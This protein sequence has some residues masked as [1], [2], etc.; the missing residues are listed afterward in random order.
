MDGVGRAEAGRTPGPALALAAHPRRALLFAADAAG[1]VWRWAPG[2]PARA[3]D[4]ARAPA[5]ALALDPAGAR[6]AAAC[7]DGAVRVWD[8]A[9]GALRRTLR[10]PARRVHAVAWAADG[11]ALVSAG[12]GGGGAVCVW[13]AEGGGEGPARR[14]LHGHARDVWA[15]AAHPTDP[16]RLA[17]A[18]DDR[19]VRLWRLADAGPAAERTLVGHAFAVVA[20]AASPRHLVSADIDGALRVWDWASGACARELAR[21]GDALAWAWW[22]PGAPLCALRGGRELRVW[23]AAAAEPAAWADLGATPVA[24]AVTPRPAAPGRLAAARDGLAAASR[25]CRLALLALR[26]PRERARARRPA[27]RL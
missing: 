11:R 25:D 23:D 4:R 26:T 1:G 9:G 19:T 18:S 27:A 8:A 24:L 5:L 15:L 22:R 7:E 20:L 2:A 21:G 17:S 3:L 14:V 16:A 12:G 13:D 10:G 6:L